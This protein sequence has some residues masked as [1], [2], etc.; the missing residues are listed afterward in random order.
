MRFVVNTDKERREM[1]DSIGIGSVQELFKDIDEEILLKRPLNLQR[2]LSEQELLEAFS[3]ISGKNADT[4]RYKCFLGAG[5]YDHFIP[6]VVPCLVG[7]SEFYTAYTPY[8]AEASQG[9]LQAIYE[10]QTLICQ[11]TGMDVCNASLYDGASALAEAAIMASNVSRRGEVI[12]SSTIHPE[13]REVVKTYVEN[14]GLEFREVGWED[15][16]T[17]VTE[18]AKEV[19]DK[20]SAVL[21]Q[22][23]N[24][25]GN[26]ED[27]DEVGKIAHEK[28]ALFVVCVVEPTSLGL[29]KA[30]GEFGADIAAGEGQSL[31][32]SVSFGG[33]HLGFLAARQEFL[34]KMPGRL[35]GMTTDTEGRRGFVMTLQARE[36]HVRREKATSNICSNQALN[37]LAATV[38]LAALGRRGFRKLSTLN[39]QKARYLRSRVLELKGFEA[40]FEKPYYNEFVV[41]CPIDPRK[42]NEELTKRSILGGLPVGRFY[43]GLEDCW[44][45]CATEKSARKDIDLLIE[46]LRGICG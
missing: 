33:P 45:L 8:Q 34:Q 14:R 4:E 29:L 35:V 30:P 7:R 25:F 10:F 36:Q 15:G 39:A 2:P 41:R 6:S 28:K 11:L 46:T 22:N 37:A 19:S 20:T 38:Y 13:Y 16:V 18:L 27:L 12:A 9:M 24:F 40:R 3:E 21:V 1:M 31:G 43:R 26:L 32:N 42:I 17:S 44:L 5:A 23:P